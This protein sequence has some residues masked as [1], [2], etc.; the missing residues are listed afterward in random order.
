MTRPLVT[1]ALGPLDRLMPEPSLPMLFPTAGDV[2]AIVAQQLEL[3][4]IPVN[5]NVASLGVATGAARVMLD[6]LLFSVASD[7][8]EEMTHVPGL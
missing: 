7:P 1:P 2:V 5:L 6:A 8:S 3:A 4:G